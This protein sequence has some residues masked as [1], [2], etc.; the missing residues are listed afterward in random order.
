MLSVYEEETSEGVGMPAPIKGIDTRQAL[1]HMDPETCVLSFNLM[2]KDQ[3]CEVRKGYVEY[4]NGPD[5]DNPYTMV[6]YNGLAEDGTDDKLFMCDEQGIWD[7]ST[8]GDT[9]PTEVHTWAAQTDGAGICSYIQ[10]VDTDG[11]SYILLCDKTNGYHVWTQSTTTWA[12][13]AQGTGATQIASPADPATF[14]YVMKWKERVWFIAENTQTAWYLDVLALYGTPTKF[15]FGNKHPHGGFLSSLH[16]FTRD[17]GAGA[18]DLMVALSS[19]G[20]V[21]LWEATNP[22]LDMDMRGR[23]FIGEVP[24]IGRRCGVEYGGDVYL[25]SVA[26]VSSVSSLIEG[27]TL[28]NERNLLTDKIGPWV[29]EVMSHGRNTFGWGLVI[30][31]KDGTMVITTPAF[32]SW[33]RVQFVLNLTN[34]A[35]AI[36]RDVP[37]EHGAMYRNEFYFCTT[38]D[39]ANRVYYYSGNVDDIRIA[40]TPLP[41]SITW[42]VL[43]AFSN[44]GS[45]MRQK[46][47]HFIR[48]IFTAGSHPSYNIEARYDFD[49]TEL[50]NTPPSSVADLAL[51]GDTGTFFHS[52]KVDASDNVI[53]SLADGATQESGVATI[54]VTIGTHAGAIT[55]TWSASTSVYEG[56]SVGVGAYMSGTANGTTISLTIDPAGA[57]A[58]STYNQTVDNDGTYWGSVTQTFGELTPLFISGS[59][60]AVL[61]AGV[62]NADVWN[63]AGINPTYGA[64]G[65]GRY[66]GYAMRGSS[67]N[68]SKFIAVD[69]VVESGGLL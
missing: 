23:W 4:G 43:S 61:G 21:S 9:S 46:Q 11:A 40:G 1:G 28:T 27:K 32:T 17:G 44:F 20:D 63:G 24:T 69:M 48:P 10:H 47:V 19:S 38:Q 13:I 57:L 68:T 56:S 59:G 37:I 51:W 29:R 55:C 34:Q 8:S 67:V 12:K 18:D 3:G 22:D 5:G 33:K 58:S 16:S 64:A 25:L 54:D 49:T 39:S 31:S 66:V 52:I 35:W 14:A 45:P 53:I 62:W 41:L 60:T 2:P 36:W 65:M 6:S 50:L 15:E 42:S 30:N 26:G 7:V